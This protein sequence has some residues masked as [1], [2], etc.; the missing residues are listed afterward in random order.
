MLLFCFIIEKNQG[1]SSDFV[2]IPAV[3][4]RRNNDFVG[5]MLNIGGTDSPGFF[6]GGGYG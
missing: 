3:I 6:L 1:E 4:H 2:I 5:G